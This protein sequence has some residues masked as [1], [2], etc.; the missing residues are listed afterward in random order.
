MAGQ[1]YAL[2]IHHILATT[3]LDLVLN[4]PL[5]PLGNVYNPVALV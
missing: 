1:G 4:L 3:Q 2:S 5:L